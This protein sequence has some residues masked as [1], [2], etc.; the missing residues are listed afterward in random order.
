VGCGWPVIV[1]ALPA[2]P[3]MREPPRRHGRHPKPPAFEPAPSAGHIP[4]NPAGRVPFNP[5]GPV[6]F[7]PQGPVPFNPQGRVP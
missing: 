3:V 5:Q 1:S 4:T 2:F 6:P 7:N